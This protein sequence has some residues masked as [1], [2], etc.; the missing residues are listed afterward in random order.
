MFKRKLTK[1]MILLKILLLETRK[2]ESK[3]TKTFQKLLKQI[4]RSPQYN[5]VGRTSTGEEM[6]KRKLTKNQAFL[7]ILVPQLNNPSEEAI[8]GSNK[9]KE[10]NETMTLQNEEVMLKNT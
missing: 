2:K 9:I 5:G 10:E 8:F 7:E 6:F 1:K 4:I 3:K